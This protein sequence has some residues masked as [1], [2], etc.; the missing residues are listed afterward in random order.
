MKMVGETGLEP[1]RIAT[2]DPKYSAFS[3]YSLVVFGVLL[4]VVLDY[5]AYR[6]THKSEKR[7]CESLTCNPKINTNTAVPAEKLIQ[8]S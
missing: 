6:Q 8:L 7:N 1:A 4:D 5:F 2:L 3:R